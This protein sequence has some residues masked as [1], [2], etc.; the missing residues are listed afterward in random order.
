MA[1]PLLHTWEAGRPIHRI[2]AAGTAAAQFNTSGRGNARFSP[3]AYA[4]GS[5]VPTL[6]GGST[7]SCAAMETVFHDLPKD[8]ERYLMDFADLEDARVSQI[9]P[10]R[11]LT[12]L[13]LTAV[14]LRRLKLKKTEIIETGIDT[15]PATRAQALAWHRSQPA[16]DGLYWISRQDDRAQACMLFGDRIEATALTVACNAQPLQET[17]HIDALLALAHDIGIVQGRSFPS[18]VT[19]F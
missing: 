18:A 14:G 19:G 4:D 12:L 15:Y 9:S 6:Y 7:F 17:P 3:L 8:I 13:S 2:H 16:I 5:I 11:D 1:E 10:A